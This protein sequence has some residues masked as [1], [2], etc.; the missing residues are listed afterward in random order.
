[1]NARTHRRPSGRAANRTADDRIGHGSAWPVRVR[2][3]RGARRRGRRDPN[4][5]YHRSWSA[6]RT[7]AGTDRGHSRLRGRA[8]CRAAAGACDDRS[9]RAAWHRAHRPRREHAVVPRPHDLLQPDRRQEPEPRVSGQTR[10]ERLRADR[11][12]DHQPDHRA[13]RL[14]CG[15]SLGRRQR[16]A[17]AVQLL[18][19]ARPQRSG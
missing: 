12:R 10:R 8:D 14:P 17:A 4:S 13:R 7:D 16:V 2:F 5:H 18:E 1:M 19:S 3:H 11:L 9:C 15:H 6:I